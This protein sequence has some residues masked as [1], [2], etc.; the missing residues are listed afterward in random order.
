MIDIV[1]ENKAKT[2]ESREQY[3]VSFDLLLRF[4]HLTLC[5]RI[6]LGC[7]LG[8]KLDSFEGFLHRAFFCCVA[9]A[10]APN[11]KL[12]KQRRRRDVE[13]C[14]T[15]L[16][17]STRLLFTAASERIKR[18][19]HVRSAPDHAWILLNFALIDASEMVV[20][21]E[22]VSMMTVRKITWL[23]T[24]I[25]HWKTSLRNSWGNSYAK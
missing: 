11:N 12:R 25:K 7:S 8:Y 9:G 21:I 4:F 16:T 6:Q 5:T 17:G 3:D 2:K 10:N 18:L 24:V 14:T 1:V 15:T 23:R 19:L 22:Y 20:L 13:F